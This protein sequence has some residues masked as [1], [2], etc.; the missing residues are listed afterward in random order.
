[1]VAQQPDDEF[2]EQHVTYTLH[3][4]DRLVVV[5]NVPA[6]VSTRTGERFFA[7][8]TVERLQQIVWDQRTPVR[9]LTTPVFDFPAPVA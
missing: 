1:M 6:R 4:G 9:V 7:P 3:V 8:D 5:Q 2:V